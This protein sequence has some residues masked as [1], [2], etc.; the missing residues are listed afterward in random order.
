MAY[1]AHDCCQWSAC[2][3]L[4]RHKSAFAANCRTLVA[5]SDRQLGTSDRQDHPGS[6]M[7][8][9]LILKNMLTAPSAGHVYLRA[10]NGQRCA[11]N[12]R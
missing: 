4:A 5:V 9:I 12:V 10:A 1:V 8:W 11:A 2:S 7:R 3:G 6:L